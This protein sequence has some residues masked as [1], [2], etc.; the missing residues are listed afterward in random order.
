[1]ERKATKGTKDKTR[2]GRKMRAE[3]FCGI[4]KTFRSGSG[5]SHF[6]QTA[7]KATGRLKTSTKTRHTTLFWPS[8]WSRRNW[9]DGM[10]IVVEE[11]GFGLGGTCGVPG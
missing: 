3:K 7:G 11:R 9:F 4:D 5:S 10:L 6:A 2:G 1:M 8:R